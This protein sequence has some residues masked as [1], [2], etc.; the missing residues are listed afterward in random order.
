MLAETENAQTSGATKYQSLV[1]TGIRRVALRDYARAADVSVV[2][3]TDSPEA[4]YCLACTL[5][6]QGQLEDAVERFTTL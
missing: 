2:N 6:Q 3:G 1:A 4:H 5:G